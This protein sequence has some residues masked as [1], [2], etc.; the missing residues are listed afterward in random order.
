M[1]TFFGIYSACCASWIGGFEAWFGDSSMSGRYTRSRAAVFTL[2]LHWSQKFTSLSEHTR[3]P[4]P[5][6]QKDGGTLGEPQSGTS[7][8]EQP[9]KTKLCC[10]FSSPKSNNEA[11]QSEH[12]ERTSEV[13]RVKLISVIHYMLWVFS[14][15][16]YSGLKGTL[17]PVGQSE[18]WTGWLTMVI[19]CCRQIQDLR[20][21]F[22]SAAEMCDAHGG[23]LGD[24]G[25]SGELRRWDAAALMPVNSLSVPS[26]MVTS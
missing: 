16:S 1:F 23:I 11:H 22:R 12:A 18:Y 6:G 3:G 26:L 21:W 15:L 19:D 13:C 25:S 2:K 7:Y 20:G 24:S 10:L 17:T 9:Q 8:P 4:R 5:N 14:I